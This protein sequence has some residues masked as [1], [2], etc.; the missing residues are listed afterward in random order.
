MALTR[1]HTS[2][3]ETIRVAVTGTSGSGRSSAGN[4]TNKKT[5]LILIVTTVF[6]YL[7]DAVSSVLSTATCLAGWLADGSWLGGCPSHTP[8]LYKNG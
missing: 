3:N 5:A 1:A 8:V 7:R 6:F 2:I 4:L